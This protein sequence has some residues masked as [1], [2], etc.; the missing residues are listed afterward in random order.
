MNRI[1]MGL[2]LLCFCLE[3]SVAQVEVSGEISEDTMWSQS[4]YRLTGDVYIYGSTLT[5]ASG[6][7]VDLQGFRLLIRSGMNSAGTYA[8]GNL[9]ATGVTFVDANGRAY[10]SSSGSQDQGVTYNAGGTISGCTFQQVQILLEGQ[11][12]PTIRN[13]TFSGNTVPIQFLGA[14]RP[15]IENNNFSQCQ[16]PGI[17]LSAQL[18]YGYGISINEDYTLPNFGVPYFLINEIY[19]YGSTLTIASGVKVDLQGFRLL[20]RSGMNSAGTYAAGNLNA[21]G[22]TFVDANGRAYISSSGSQDQGVTYN[23]GGT[24]SGCTFQQVAV[25]VGGYSRPIIIQSR[26]TKS[27]PSIKVNGDGAPQIDHC[28]FLSVKTIGVEN[29]G[30]GAVQA[31]NNYWGDPTGPENILNPLGKGAG[32]SGHVNFLPFL[33]S[34]V[35][36]P[37]YEP[38]VLS[39]VK[40]ASLQTGQET[41]RSLAAGFAFRNPPAKAAVETRLLDVNSNAEIPLSPSTYTI[42][43]VGTVASSPTVYFQLP[44]SNNFSGKFIFSV[45]A[46]DGSGTTTNV[47]EFTYSNAGF[48]FGNDNYCFFNTDETLQNAKIQAVKRRLQGLPRPLAIVVTPALAGQYVFTRGLCYGMSSTALAYK[49]NPGLIPISGKTTNQLSLTD[50]GVAENL[51][52]YQGSQPWDI[53]FSSLVAQFDDQRLDQ[54]KQIRAYLTAGKGID[55]NITGRSVSHTVVAVGL[56]SITNTATVLLYDPNCQAS[57]A[58]VCQ[59][60]NLDIG[61]HIGFTYDGSSMSSVWVSDPVTSHNMAK[62]KIVANQSDGGNTY[63]DSL[64]VYS[65]RYMVENGKQYV[66]LW[67]STGSPSQETLSITVSAGK[68]GTLKADRDSVSNTIFG[69]RVMRFAGV[70]VIELPLEDQYQIEANAGATCFV[71]TEMMKAVQNG[72]TNVTFFDD[73]TVDA[74]G[75]VSMQVTSGSTTALRVDKKGDGTN[76]SYMSPA[77]SGNV[78]TSFPTG[79]IAVPLNSSLF[80][81]YPNPF[82]PTTTIRYGLPN[83]SHVT[84]TVFN[85]LGQQIAQLQNGEQEAGYHE[86]KF[87]GANLP[88]GMYFYR[89]QAGNY[90]ETKK[91]LLLK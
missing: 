3:L 59:F 76:V 57:S 38:L 8:A 63:L 60:D 16:L 37:I 7:K 2:S 12:T 71:R 75:K 31:Q 29:S 1:K 70:C 43:R 45:R 83:R 11:C 35:D 10:I 30:S 47:M 80:Q 50:P 67:D 25:V 72:A 84:L 52:D 48:V 77:Y 91:L 22:V 87:D 6:V 73:A 15:V 88:S 18:N 78:V 27:S 9:N 42:T 49:N 53:V 58:P 65:N 46:L 86:V 14:A 26:F 40:I 90:V 5:I 89:M 51:I 33:S 32:V 19:I 61:D 4:S 56:F 36:I 66:I 21:T 82:N 13:S 55:L 81:N 39:W 17:G 44:E 41:S 28:N 64:L 62:Q 69:A 79:V 74:M 20:I 34:P 68:G 54:L 24:I 23:A 85:T